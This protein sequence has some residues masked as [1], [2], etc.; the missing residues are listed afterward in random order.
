M[1]VSQPTGGGHGGDGSGAMDR[2]LPRACPQTVAVR[3]AASRYLD[4]RLTGLM[5]SVGA[6]CGP[7]AMSSDVPHPTAT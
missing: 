4:H 1:F 2:E 6:G 5:I 7:M 3:N